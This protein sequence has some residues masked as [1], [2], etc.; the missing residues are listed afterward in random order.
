M[1]SQ[2]SRHGCLTAYL[3]LMLIA[4][5]GTALIY[6]L[7]GDMVLQAFPDA[8]GW[9]IPVL[10]FVTSFNFVCAIALFKWK[11]WG[12]WGFCVSAVA[13]LGINLAIGLG[14]GSSIGGLV[15]VAILYGVLHIGDNNK[16][17]SQLD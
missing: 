6:L 4:N 15:G 9:T 5:A 13:A 12:F 2:K 16:G 14:P 8:P 3:I 1:S 10:V 11:K 17:W 7:A